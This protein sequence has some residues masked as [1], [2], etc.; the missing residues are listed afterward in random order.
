MP[1][2]A[3]ISAPAESSRIDLS[4]IIVSYNTREL[5]ARCITSVV[6]NTAGI[7]YRIYVVD[8]ASSDGSA[9][10]VRARYPEV[11]L[12]KNR[13]NLGFAQAN[14]QVMGKIDS[15][16]V[17]LLNSDTACPPGSRVLE[18]M[19]GHL[20]AHPEIGALGPRIV[21]PDG[22]IQL[23][24]ARSFPTLWTVFC[25]FS[26]LA[27]RFPNNRFTGGYL[28]SYWDHKTSREVDLLLGA[29]MMVREEVIEQV[30]PLDG[31]FFL[32]G[33]DVDWCRRIKDAGWKIYYL[34]DL[35]LEHEGGASKALLPVHESTET[36]KAWF[37][38]FRKHHGLAYAVAGRLIT[39]GFLLFWV[40][41]Y[42]IRYAF[43]PG[44]R[45]ALAQTIKIRVELLTW[46]LSGR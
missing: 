32:G 37:L 17:V 39:A 45:E 9:E 38:Y 10:M 16:Y 27:Q 36:H 3:P 14:S 34:S 29:C 13:E 15:R 11:I 2:E 12:E 18:R 44:Q 35:T 43:T 24:C 28:M 33:E 26:S 22:R 21:Y 31:Q 20:D 1:P 42:S 5:L 23:H 25:M 4:I 30:G 41:F 19:V 40:S 8:N 6:E 46:C 7:S